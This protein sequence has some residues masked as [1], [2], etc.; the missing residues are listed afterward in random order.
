MA[1]GTLET[2]AGVAEF[3]L[4]A[5]GSDEVEYTGYTDVWWDELHPLVDEGGNVRLVCPK[6]HD[7]AAREAPETT[8][9]GG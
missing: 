3:E 2:V 6:G 4:A 5:D 8:S 9:R 7:W 1:R